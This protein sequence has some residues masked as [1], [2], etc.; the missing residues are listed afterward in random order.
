MNEDLLEACRK[1]V[2]AGTP[3]MKAFGLALRRIVENPLG[4]CSA[5]TALKNGKLPALYP[6]VQDYLVGNPP[7]A[8]DFGGPWY[9]D[10]GTGYCDLNDWFMSFYNYTGM[11]WDP[12]P[13]ILTSCHTYLV[14]SVTKHSMDVVTCSNVINTL[15]E[16][17]RDNLLLLAGLALK[18]GT[19]KLFMSAYPGDRSGILALSSSGTLQTNQPRLL[20][21]LAQAHQ[22]VPAF[23]LVDPD[24]KG[25]SSMCALTCPS[26]AKL[27]DW[28]DRRR[29]M[30][31][32]AEVVEDRTCAGRSRGR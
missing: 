31:V 7:G 3:R 5:K 10:L 18:E 13:N 20:K 11:C 12:N 26:H 15:P 17:Q 2:E 25:G 8:D 29:R 4:Q 28:Y 9:L 30:Y 19:G 27:L 21:W 16:A 32:K 1:A 23:L 6:K 14:E 24:F 22:I